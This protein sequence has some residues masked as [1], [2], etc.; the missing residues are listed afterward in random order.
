MTRVFFLTLITTGAMMA[1]THG[2][3]FVAP[4][5]VSYG[6]SLENPANKGSS[7]LIHLGFGGEYVFK[8]TIGAGA[9]VG[10]RR[11]RCAN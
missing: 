7:G 11:S 9:E 3:V 8:N 2:Y 10:I 4:G 6:N 1:Q 5:V